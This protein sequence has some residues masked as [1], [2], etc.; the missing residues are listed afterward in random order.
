MGHDVTI[1]C[2]GNYKPQ[3]EEVLM[4]F[5]ND[6]R[7]YQRLAAVRPATHPGA[8]HGNE[9][10]QFYPMAVREVFGVAAEFRWVHII[11]DVTSLLRQG[12]AVQSCL[13][14]PGHY[15]AVVAWDENTQ[16]LIFNDPWP[17]RFPDGNGFNQ[18]MDEREY[19]RNVKPFAIVYGGKNE[20]EIK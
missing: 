11:D 8:W 19:N 12:K 18:R 7:N 6:P 13:K 14:E 1:T 15:I 5:F 17:T 10:P 4:D 2:P 20:R 3:A 16:E 9:V